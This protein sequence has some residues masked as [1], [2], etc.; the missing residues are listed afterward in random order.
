[1]VASI[2]VSVSNAQIR[3]IVYESRPQGG[4]AGVKNCDRSGL[5]HIATTLLIGRGSPAILTPLV[6]MS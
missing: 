6:T 3:S 5:A 2:P 1:M 4:C